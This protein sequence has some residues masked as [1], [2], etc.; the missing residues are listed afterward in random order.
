[1]RKIR[2]MNSRTRIIIEV[3][4]HVLFWILPTYLIIRYNMMSYGELTG[5]YY[6][7][8]LIIS[9]LINIFLVYTNIFVLFPGYRRKRINLFM[10][11]LILI[12]MAGALAMLKVMID[13]S[14]MI[15]Y[16][17]RI[18]SGEH[19]RIGM[20]VFVNSF[21]AVQSVLYCIVSEWITNMRAERV[22]REE[23]L[24]LELKYLKSQINPHFLFN[25]LNNLYSVALK[26]DDNETANGITKLSQMMRFMLDGVNEDLIPLEKEITYLTSY[27]D[28]QKLRFSEQDDVRISFDVKGDITGIRIPSFIFI[29]FIEN[30]FKYGIDYN[31]HS[32][33]DIK[34]EVSDNTLKFNIRNSIHKTGDLQNPGIGLKNIRDRL[35]LLYPGSHSLE[36]GSENNIFNLDLIIRLS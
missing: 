30:A 15:H 33:V 2:H 34:F 4:C 3:I 8:P 17:S 12:I 31:K 29:V 14:F 11:V 27:L 24:T 5:I 21:F 1:M 28:L 36:I 20:E 26:N 18:V 19:Y 16:F 7:M 25:T 22:L 23:K 9:V 35:D 32:F 13:N 10:Y 6:R